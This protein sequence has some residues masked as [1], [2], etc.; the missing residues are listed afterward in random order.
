MYCRKC[1]KQIN[2][3]APY[4][5]ECEETEKFFNAKKPISTPK[6]IPTITAT[7]EQRSK[8]KMM[9][10][11]KALAS[12]IVGTIAFIL[13]ILALSYITM[14]YDAEMYISSYRLDDWTTS[15][16]TCSFLALGGAIPGLIL[17][18]SSVKCFCTAKKDGR[19]KPIAT[20]V[21]GLVGLVSSALTL[22]YISLSFFMLILV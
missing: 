5:K 9:F 6:D 2:Y 7:P 12:T 22:I 1:G 15:C 14:V 19:E 17:G 20:L 16:I 18:I 11:G 3:D 21:C 4:C 13:G 8:E 10:F